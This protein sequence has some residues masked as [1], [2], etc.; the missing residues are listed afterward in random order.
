VLAAVFLA[1]GFGFK[2]AIVPF[3][4]WVP[5]VY[6]GAPTTVTA[7]L[8]VASKAA[9]FAVAMRVFAVSLGQGLISSDWSNMFAAMA[10]VSMVI[11]NVLA[12]V[13]TDIKRLLGSARSRRAGRSLSAWRRSRRTTLRPSG[14]KLR[15]VLH[16]TYAFTNLGAFA[17]II[18]I[19]ERIDSDEIAITQGL[20]KRSPLAGAGVAACLI[21]LTGFRRRP[22]FIAGVRVQ[23]AV[24]RRTWCGW[25]RRMLASVI[26][27][28]YLRVVMTMFT[29]RARQ[30]ARSSRARTLR[31]R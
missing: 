18:A 5:D 13:Q 6:Q 1:A 12:L 23:H 17:A 4:M 25:P 14:T 24:L 31:R 22:G 29:R 9:G 11:G 20:Y 26:S 21:S 19:S 15:D 16:R 27:A 28:Y 3:Q 7:Y 8:S 2:M 10:V 30:R